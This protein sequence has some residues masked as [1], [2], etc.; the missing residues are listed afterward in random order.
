MRHKPFLLDSVLLRIFLTWGITLAVCFFR[1]NAGFAQADSVDVTFFYK[2]SGNPSVVYLAGEF[3]NWAN[4]QTGQ[5][6]DHR[7]AMSFDEAT[8]CWVKTVRLRVGGPSPLPW[9]GSIPGAYQYKFNENGSSSGWIPDP[10]N[11]RQNPLDH[12]N[13]YL[14]INN[15]TIHYLLPNSVSGLVRTS[16][17]EIS[18]Y[19]Y[20]SISTSVDTA[21]I[22]LVLDEKEHH[23][24]GSC[25][26]PV[27]KYFHFVLSNPLSSGTHTLKLSV[28]SSSGTWGADSTSF[29][30]QAGFVQLLTR[31]NPHYLRPTKTI[32]GTV[33]D[34][35]ITT[36][37]LFHNS[38]STMISV[39]DGR[40]SETVNLVEGNNIVWV[41]VT[42]PAG[43]TRTSNPI[44]ITYMVDH[45]PKPQIQIAV[46][47]KN[48]VLTANGHDPDGD[49]LNFVWKSD[50][51]QNPEPLGIDI[52]APSVSVPIPQMTGE[53]YVDLV[54]VDPDSNTGIARSYFAVD[55]VGNVD[56]PT[57]NSNPQW[58]RDAVVYEIFVPSFTL[59]GTLQAAKARLPWI[60]ALGAN[61]IWLMPIYEN[62]ETI[63]ELNAGYNLTNFYE[64]HPQLGTMADFDAF[65]HEA[66]AMG[67][68]VILD[69]TPNHVSTN[70]YWIDD[71]K[72]F[73][74]YSIYR[75]FIETRILG[76]NRGMGQ[77]T[78]TVDGYTLY[79][80]YGNWSL[81]NLNY[82][83]IE[84]ID[85]MLK[86]Y[87][88]WV[89]EKHI[90]GYRMDVYWGP[91]NR[92]GKAA[93]WRPFREEIKRVRPDVFILGETD[94]TGPGSENN[95]ADRGG[96]SD[97]AYDWNFYS[98]IKATLSGGNLVGL[99]NR[100]R[101]YSPILDYNFYTG[102]NAHYLR[103]LENHDEERIAK[104]FSIDKTKA[105]VALLMTIP[106]IPLIYAGQEVGETS[107][108]G[109]INWNRTG[110]QSLFKY[111]QRLVRIRNSY[112]TFR[113]PE[114]KR[115]ATNQSRVYS[116]LRPYMDQ[117][118]IVA[119]N[120]SGN[121]AV[122]TLSIKPGDLRVSTDSLLTGKVYYLNDVLNDTS[123]TV[124]K[125]TIDSFQVN[126]P[127]WGS[128]V[129]ILSDT[130]INFVT[131]IATLPVEN[132]P[133]RFTL[134]QNYPNPFNSVTTIHYIVGGEG[135]IHTT[136]KVYN[137]LGKEIRVLID[138]SQKAGFYSVLW[139]GKD[140]K[141]NEV[142]SGLYFYQ[143]RTKN[144]VQTRKMTILK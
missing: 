90:D 82:S 43:V 70:H 5:I 61:V 122:T 64:I 39:L 132:S 66:H 17:P 50:D 68:R 34:T 101:N 78:K 106:G 33:E 2:P 12:N 96:A 32:E 114:I 57:V 27:T 60:K 28:Q 84:T 51:A 121:T 73:R 1:I 46:M 85:Y 25:Y 29:I 3:N 100:V 8:G 30:V 58:V 9:S 131:K 40:F 53:Y 86:M 119:V 133:K 97:A 42:D 127:S 18:A 72:L 69:T 74:D 115:I 38:D 24:I 87:K 98:Q 123:Y 13:S 110:A 143:L 63:N 108:R 6:T 75:P 104:L 41:S 134:F 91:Q 135:Y 35:T 54:A 36:A 81:A 19:I 118:G 44:T 144:F 112:E 59:E 31:S 130:L 109:K 116:Y 20:P 99:D 14:F 55:T 11:P 4:N 138:K 142:T 141:G 129:F 65:V 71:I 37:K 16:L 140:Q 21:T 52:Q 103:F 79:V 137:T 88:W 10:L 128:S 102:P 47:G 77:Y 120:F 139:D 89:L 94:G 80:Y 107:R 56:I 92:Y 7:F 124:T 93:W 83:N 126:L 76:N 45:A 67:L 105:G 48:V 49:S 111:Y 26:D 125:S 15:P 62:G 95:Y 23:G 117:N 22:S 113:S 136:L